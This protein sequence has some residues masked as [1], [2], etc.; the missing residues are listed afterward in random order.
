MMR[1]GAFLACAA[2]EV[3]ASALILSAPWSL[4]SAR[5][6]GAAALHLTAV[7]LLAALPGPPRTRRWLCAASLLAVPG[8]GAGV[9]LAVLFTEGRG[10]ADPLT[11]L[12]EARREL[13]SRPG[14][15]PQPAIPLSPCDALGAGDLEKRR[16]ALTA[17]ARRSD[18]EAVTILRW[19]AAGSDPDLAVSAALALDEISERAEHRLAGAPISVEAQRAAV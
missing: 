8:A 18:P 12:R 6:L 3:L 11:F 1:R 14:R 15:V 13:P 7:L 2:M 10:S 16:A 9:A 5:G 17:L 4:A 19:A